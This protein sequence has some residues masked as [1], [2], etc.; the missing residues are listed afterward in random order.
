MKTMNV[1]MLERIHDL[2]RTTTPLTPQSVPIPTPGNDEILIRVTACGVC[3]TE[4]DEIEGRTPPPRFP[5]IPGHQV[6]GRVDAAG[7]GADRF[8]AGQRV[9]VAWINH[10]CGHCDYCREGLENLCPAFA[11]T[12]RD[13]HGGY[14]EYMTVHQEFAFPIPDRFSDVQ[15]APL[16]CAGA[17]GYR[18]MALCQMRDGQRLGLTGFGASAHL[19]LKMVQHLFPQSPVYVFARS[20]GEQAFALSLGAAWAGD[21]NDRPPQ[22]LDC[23]IDTTPA[24]TPVVAALANLKPGGRVV[25]N[26]IRKEVADRDVL[27]TLDYASHLW[28]EKE[29]KSVANVAR[30]DVS[31]FLQ[32]ADRIPIIPEVEIF[33]LNDANRA[34][35][36]L[37]TRKIRGG[38]VLVMG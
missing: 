17:I 24:W 19:V 23:I 29:I 38:K 31:H 15:A 35:L 30:S 9:G 33:G 20:A 7:P 28:H 25:I 18:S 21:T 22:L 10:A 4:L 32:L 1:M 2:S 37:K 3:H 36:E 27:L 26:A 34:L 14:A 12:G 11:A 8:T 5:I 13:A 6:V 16:L